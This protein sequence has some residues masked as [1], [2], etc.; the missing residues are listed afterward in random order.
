MTGLGL[1]KTTPKSLGDGSTT[2]VWPR[3]GFD[4]PDQPICEWPNHFMALGSG[5]APPQTQITIIIIK[6]KYSN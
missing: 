2:L 6:Q 3:G 4:H 1:V 5:L